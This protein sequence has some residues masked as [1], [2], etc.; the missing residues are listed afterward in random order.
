MGN[1]GQGMNKNQMN[2]YDRLI[3][4]S[5]YGLDIASLNVSVAARIILHRF[6]HWV[7]S[8][9][10]SPNE[11]LKASFVIIVSCVIVNVPIIHI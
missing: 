3:K 4:I 11:L 8:T 5:P 9:S 10:S 2:V 6:H 1:E 7:L